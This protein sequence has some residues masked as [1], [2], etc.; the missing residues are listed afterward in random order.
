MT[1]LDP[2]GGD[3]IIRNMDGVSNHILN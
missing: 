2:L 3:I 1:Y